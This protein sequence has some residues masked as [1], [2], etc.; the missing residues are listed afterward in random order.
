MSG[1]GGRGLALPLVWVL[2]VKRVLVAAVFLAGCTYPIDRAL[3]KC[4]GL[5]DE[6]LRKD[7]IVEVYE[8]EEREEP[9]D[10]GR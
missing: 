10:A 8:I 2:L 6:Q 9:T 5:E 7:C 3:E 4:A 1:R